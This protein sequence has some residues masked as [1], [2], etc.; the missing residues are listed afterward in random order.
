MSKTTVTI[1]ADTTNTDIVINVTVN[2]GA[3]NGKVFKVS[4]LD[5]NGQEYYDY[6]TSAEMVSLLNSR[7]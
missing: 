6:F 1:M 5:K 2:Q 7:K 4:F 3:N